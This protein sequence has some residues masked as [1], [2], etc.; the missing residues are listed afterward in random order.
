MPKPPNTA[1]PY[2]QCP[3]C[4]RKSRAVIYDHIDGSKEVKYVATSKPSRNMKIISI[5]L[6]ED[7]IHWLAKFPNRSE[8]IQLLVERAMGSNTSPYNT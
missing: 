5:R 1:R 8:Q 7:Q 2:G 4:K 6:P 3:K